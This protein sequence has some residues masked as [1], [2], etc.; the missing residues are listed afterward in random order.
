M[1]KAI[2]EGVIG[3]VYFTGNGSGMIDSLRWQVF[4]GGI[5]NDVHDDAI[6]SGSTSQQLSLTNVPL[7]YNGNLYRLAFK[8]HCIT[9]YTTSATLTVHSNPV[10][11]FTAVNPIAACGGVPLIINGNPTGGSGTYTQHRWTGDIGPLNNYNIQSPTFSS[12]ISGAY[13]LNYKVTDSNGCTANGD[14]TVNVDAPSATF[15]TDVSNGCTPLPVTFTKDMTGISKFWWDFGDGSPQDSVNAN[16]VHNFTDTTTTTVE[17]YSITLKVQS[18]GGC[19][20]TFTTSVTVYP[21][22]NATF[23]ASTDTICSGSSIVYTTKPGA[24]NY[25]WDFGD[26]VSGYFSNVTSHLYTTTAPVVRQVKLTTTSFYNCVDIKTMN[27]VVMPMPV[28]KFTPVPPSQIFNAGG[29]PVSFT[30]NTNA[31][32]WNWL[33]K[34][35]DGATSTVQSPSHTYTGL[36]NFTVTLFVSNTNCSDSV[37][38]IVHITPIPPVADFDSVPSGCSPLN[39][40]INNTSQNIATPGTTYFWDFNDGSTSTAKNPTYTYFTAGDYVISLTVTGPGGTSVKTQLVHAYPSPSVNFDLAPNTVYVNDQQVRFFNLTQNADHYLWEFGDGDTSMVKDPFHKYMKEG[41][42]DITL[43]AYSANGCKN[44]Y[45]LS[46]GVT[47][48]PAGVLRFS[49]V[50]TP[51]RNGPIELT[52]L[53]TGGTEIDQFFFPPI[54]E[55]VLNYDL[56]IYNR[57]GT[58]IFESHNINVPWNGY[59]KGSLCKQGVYVWIVEGKYANG[60]PFKKTGDVTLLH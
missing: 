2:C 24:K 10:V 9:V 48:Q 19:F 46:P 25:F 21:A 41:V 60:K 11:D 55:T 47:V 26:G 42:F 49:T 8:A 23:T 28:P 5:W 7:T 20:A 39:V 16:P 37:K 18:S 58:L 53:P 6:S 27:I 12:Q 15:T 59:Y 44:S 51:N 17:Y 57:W 34:F 43:W 40:D 13:N 30:N 56:Q 50:F 36:G 4:S 29:N 32:T 33:W 14:V 45:T 52:T 1:N 35:G 38:D 22:I 31:G 54:R 3:P